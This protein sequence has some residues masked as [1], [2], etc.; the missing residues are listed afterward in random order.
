MQL[1]FGANRLVFG[2]NPLVFGGSVVPPAV[3]FGGGGTIDAPERPRQKQARPAR[4][5]LAEELTRLR[6]PDAPDEAPAPRKKRV[7][8]PPVARVVTESPILGIIDE[9]QARVQAG[10]DAAALAQAAELAAYDQAVLIAEAEALAFMAADEA[11][12]ELLLL[13]GV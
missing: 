12:L 11:D 4:D 9:I 10:I 6:T 7:K 13:M 5:M 2:L 8:T 3:N 1:T